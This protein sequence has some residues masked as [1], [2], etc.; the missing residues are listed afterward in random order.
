MK[1]VIYQ[2]EVDD[3]LSSFFD[4]NLSI[5][6]EIPILLAS[7]ETFVGKVKNV[8]SIVGNLIEDDFSYQYPC[9]LATA[10]IWNLNDQVFDKYEVWKARYTPVNK[11]ANLNHNP[12]EV[13]GHTLKAFAITDEVSPKVIPSEVDG[14][15]NSDI[16]DIYHLLTVDSLYKYHIDAYKKLAGES[17]SEKLKNVYEKV[18]SGTLCVSMECIFGD[19][20]YALMDNQGN[21]RIIRRDDYSAFLTKKLRMF[22]GDGTY[23]NYRVGVIMR[24]IMFTGKGITDNPANPSSVIFG[25]D[26]LAFASQNY[27]KIVDVLEAE[28]NSA[29]ITNVNGEN[30]M[31]L[32]QLQAK[33]AELETEL[34]QS[35]K[36]LESTTVAKTQSETS[37]A[38]LT[39]EVATVS[40]KL[41]T[42][43]SAL[44][45]ANSKVDSIA[46]ELDVAKSTLATKENELSVIKADKLKS[47]RITSIKESL[48]LS[49][50]ESESHYSAVASLN[51]ENF[52]TWLDN[53]AKV[54]AASKSSQEKLAEELKKAQSEI[55]KKNAAAAS[56]QIDNADKPNQTLGVASTVADT[57]GKV[58]ESIK[59]L[60]AKT[61]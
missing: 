10:G 47:D 51:E 5:S 42:S 20:D 61:K 12:A 14:K 28:K 60:F 57:K 23:N 35:K 21:Q 27:T 45:E 6:Y 43:E 3:G 53:T 54:F 9:I 40:D 17:F 13:V 18:V 37:V 1:P 34:A 38:N 46:K 30:K 32:E 24:D 44:A 36:D 41:K 39:T 56:A 31:N 7:K 49:K 8:S 22:G 33:I 59:D 26:S 16:P 58:R 55:E 52:K 4:N 48:G 2:K 19:F 11:P 15:P 29:Y 50:E 25:K